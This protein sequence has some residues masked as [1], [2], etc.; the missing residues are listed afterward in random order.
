M[1]FV[2][3]IL[4]ALYHCFKVLLLMGSSDHNINVWQVIQP[5]W[6]EA[7]LASTSIYTPLKNIQLLRTVQGMGLGSLI[8][9]IWEMGDLV[10]SKC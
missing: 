2:P 3:W 9:F 8:I 5:L 7:N 1:Y 6:L 4:S 10:F